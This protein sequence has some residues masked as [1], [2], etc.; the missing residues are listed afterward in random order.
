MMAENEKYLW[1]IEYKPK[2]IVEEK[3]IKIMP[4]ASFSGEFWR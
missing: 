4:H 1:V 3:N 2:S